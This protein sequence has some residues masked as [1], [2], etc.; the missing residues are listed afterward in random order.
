MGISDCDV[1]Y[2]L[3][4]SYIDGICTAATRRCVEEHLAACPACA[5]RAKRLR[6]TALTGESL[7]RITLDA[8]KKIKRRA[9]R[10]AAG[11]LLLALPFVLLGWLAFNLCV[12]S[13]GQL[14]GVLI[15]RRELYVLLAACLL[16]GALFPRGGNARLQRRDYGALA[17]SLA[18][19]AASIALMV[20]CYSILL[21]GAP[22]PNGLWTPFG[23][24]RPESMDRVFHRS[25]GFL[26]LVQTAV[27]LWAAARLCRKNIRALPVFQT[28]LTGAALPLLYLLT[29]CCMDPS[30][31]AIQ[32]LIPWELR[33]T[34]ILLTLGL[35]GVL[36]EFVAAKW[37]AGKKK[38]LPFGKDLL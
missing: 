35:G 14:G 20:W 38:D 8:A 11:H 27:C 17:V 23:V 12:L 37:R 18:A 9:V 31:P 15:R 28:A 24:L 16:A 25:Y 6:D 30:V 26:T 21:P 19:M 7:A 32:D 33:N 10:R 22:F 36:L 1:I 29:L 2:D 5:E 3:L 13:R 4:P 34:G